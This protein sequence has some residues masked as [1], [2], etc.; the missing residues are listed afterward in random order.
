[1]RCDE[2]FVSDEG[3]LLGP[4]SERRINDLIR[5]GKLS[6]RAFVAD[7]D[8]SAW[9]S[10]QKSAFASAMAERSAQQASV[11]TPRPPA[12]GRSFVRSMRGMRD[13]LLAGALAVSMVILAL[14]S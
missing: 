3:T 5:W 1:M 4:L 7:G 13:L 14:A 2:W 12:T 6:E 9:V 11:R 10:I 8:Y